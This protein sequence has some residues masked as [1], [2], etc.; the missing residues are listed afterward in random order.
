MWTEGA[1][2]NPFAM[3]RLAR[4]NRLYSVTGTTPSPTPSPVSPGSNWLN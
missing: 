3:M 1:G 4:L 2:I